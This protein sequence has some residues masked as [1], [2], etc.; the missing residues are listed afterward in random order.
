M[1]AGDVT[2][3]TSPAT[4]AAEAWRAILDFVGATSWR[5][6]RALADLGL[7]I[8]DSRAL[9]SLEYETGRTM[10]SLAAEWSCDASTATW[11][12]DRL[13]QRGL[14]ERRAHAPDRRVRL[15][16]LTPAGLEMRE[17]MLRRVYAAPPELLDL[18][19]ADLLALRDGVA[20]LPTVTSAPVAR[21]PR[22]R[23]AEPHPR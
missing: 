8:N 2:T 19:L 14:A 18:D 7:T 13:E 17:E 22:E 9:T 10:R 4:I 3:E 20:R 16:V 23:P 11:I 1:Y 21:F 15:A 5:R 12:V 6:T